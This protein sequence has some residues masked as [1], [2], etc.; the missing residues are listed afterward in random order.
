M[1]FKILILNYVKYQQIQKLNTE[2]SRSVYSAGCFLLYFKCS[3]LIM[4]I[5]CSNVYEILQLLQS[6]KVS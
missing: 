5:G 6:L 4:G 1:E 2:I 3:Y